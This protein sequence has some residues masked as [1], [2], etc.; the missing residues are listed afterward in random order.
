MRTEQMVVDELLE[1]EA[2]LQKKLTDVQTAIRV[3]YEMEVKE[4]KWIVTPKAH[5][6]Y[7]NN[8]EPRPPRNCKQCGTEFIPKSK[9]SWFCSPKCA[10]S[11][12]NIKQRSKN[13]IKKKSA[14][15]QNHPSIIPA[16][17]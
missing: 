17:N 10:K 6:D 5:A 16:P 9:V 14:Q 15:T 2:K 7:V 4:P 12:S 1:L 11:D 13:K 8:V 3:L